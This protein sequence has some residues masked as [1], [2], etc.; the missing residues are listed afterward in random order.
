GRGLQATSIESRGS[1]TWLKI[2]SISVCF[3]DRSPVSHGFFLLELSKALEK[4]GYTGK[5]KRYFKN[6]ELLLFEK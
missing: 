3:I 5:R 1:E 6:G 4:S 2:R